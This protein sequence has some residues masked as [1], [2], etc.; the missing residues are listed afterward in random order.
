MEDAIST[1]DPLT[2]YNSESSEV[3]GAYRWIKPE[4]NPKDWLKYMSCYTKEPSYT[5]FTNIKAGVDYIFYQ[6]DGLE[7]ARVLD[8][9]SYNKYLYDNVNCLPFLPLIP[10]D[11]FSLVT[12]FIITK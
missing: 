3:Y 2:F 9:P 8:L 6:G 12:D 4:I 11:H 7:V 1:H 5:S 10:S